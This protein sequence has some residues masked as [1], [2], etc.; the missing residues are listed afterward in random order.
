MPRELCY[1]GMEAEVRLLMVGPVPTQKDI[2][3]P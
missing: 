1:H 2:G 3:L